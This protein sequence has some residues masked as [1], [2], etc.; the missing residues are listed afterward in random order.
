L[1]QYEKR[2]N[3]V[4]ELMNRVAGLAALLMVEADKAVT[5]AVQ[6]TQRMKGQA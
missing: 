2:L 3:E 5:V 4:P 6:A 1:E